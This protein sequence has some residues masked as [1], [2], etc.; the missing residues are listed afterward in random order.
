MEIR[1]LFAC[2]ACHNGLEEDASGFFCSQCNRNY[3]YRFGLPDFRLSPDPY[4]GIDDEIEKVKKILGDG[5]H[6]F[7]RLVERYYE[8]TP[9]VS[10]ALQPRYIQ[11]LKSGAVRADNFLNQMEKFMQFSGEPVLDIGC[12]TAGLSLIFARRYGVTVVGVDIALRWLVIGKQRLKEADVDASLICAGAEAL[13]FKD[14]SFAGAI[15]DSAI[16]HVLGTSELF[17]EIR[18]VV[19]PGGFFYF[20]TAN[21]NS[22][23]EAYTG[24]PMAGFIPR[25]LR[26]PLIE[27]ICKTPYQL[28]PLTA[29]QLQKYL[30]PSDQLNVRPFKPLMDH[31]SSAGTLRRIL[32]LLYSRTLESKLGNRFLK[33]FGFFLSASGY[34]PA[35]AK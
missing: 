29:A 9:E 20:N 5:D 7:E 10:A 28:N 11:G 2:P 26:L 6:S 12:G 25:K 4:I 33:H 8:F 31:Y 18:R 16:E 23:L 3:P 32:G 22:L 24:F 1:Q 21:K 35:Q 34:F 30:A 14:H 15:S 27:S 17:H 19:K 13:P